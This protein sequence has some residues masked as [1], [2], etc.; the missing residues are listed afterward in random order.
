MPI[1][2]S[3][4]SAPTVGVEK[5]QRGDEAYRAFVALERYLGEQAAAV[6]CGE[7]GGANSVTPLRVAAQRGLSVLDADPMGHVTIRGF[8]RH[9]R[10]PGLRGLRGQHAARG[11]AERESCGMAR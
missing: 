2:V 10:Y 4:M 5:L 3:G 1:A 9:R 11:D 7:I 6:V 8:A